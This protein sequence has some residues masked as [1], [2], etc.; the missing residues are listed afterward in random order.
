MK[1]LEQPLPKAIA[2]TKEGTPSGFNPTCAY[3]DQVL[4]GGF[5][6]LEI[7]ASPDK[8]SIVHRTLVEA[9]EYP[10]KL[11]YLKLTDRQQGQ[12]SKPESYVA[13]EISKDRMLQALSSY[14]N[15]FYH[16]G[17]HQL[18]ILGANE[19]QIVLDELGVIYLYPDDFLFRDLLTQLG[20]SNQEHQSMSEQDYVQ[21]HFNAEAD[22]EEQSLMT[23]FGLTRWEG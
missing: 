2:V 12:L 15:L 14:Q 6:R 9:I 18:W 21:V 19:E 17:R 10:C 3:K 16:D 5:T 23:S 11:R 13:V 20:W 22:L 7:S 4:P 8:L 1:A